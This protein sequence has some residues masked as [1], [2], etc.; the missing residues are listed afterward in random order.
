ML[1][2]GLTGGIGAGKSTVAGVLRE[3]GALVVEA[4]VVARQVVAPGTRGLTAVVREFG[5]QVLDPDGALD[6]PALARLAFADPDRR[7]ALEAITHPLV[8]AR[9]EELVAAAPADAVVV[10]DVPLLVEK[11]MGAQYH[12]V[13][14][15]DAPEAVRE[16]RLVAG[17]GM[18]AQDVRLRI[19]CQADDS[20]RRAA[21]DVWLDNDRSPRDVRSDIKV[22]WQDRLRPFEHH[23]RTRTPAR[24]PDSVSA[25]G[26]VAD[27]A[28]ADDAVAGDA[29]A[30]DVHRAARLLARIHRAV[31]E[32]GADVRHDGSTG[33]TVRLSWAVPGDVDRDT[34][35]AQLGDAGFPRILG[36]SNA[37]ECR[38]GSADPYVPVDLVVRM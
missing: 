37:R 2:V 7:R 1:R 10:H 27:D 11:D 14:V 28:V 32:R 20:S 30:G 9:T 34:L 6:R 13:V 3:A 17:R 38:Y 25:R 22:L 8:A 35:E 33:G 31:G 4:D 19:R 21:A 18:D 5:D 36:G 23:V 29:V 24:H 12:L 16:Q 26:A 15:V